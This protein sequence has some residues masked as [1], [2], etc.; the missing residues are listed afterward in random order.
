MFLFTLQSHTHQTKLPL[1]LLGDIVQSRDQGRKH[2]LAPLLVKGHHFRRPLSNT[3]GG[4]LKLGVH[5]V[6]RSR[7]TPRLQT[8]VVVRVLAPAESR[9]RLDR[10]DG[11]ARGEDR[12]LVC[13][14]LGVEDFETG[15]RD[16]TGLDALFGKLGEAFVTEADFGAG[17]DEGDVGC[18][19]SA[20]LDA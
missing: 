19:D 10:H 13:R 6:I 11:R 4:E 3:L 2:G 5:L 17:R 16:E 9:V 8:K 20:P 12:E 14:V 1:P 18:F 7:G 15:E